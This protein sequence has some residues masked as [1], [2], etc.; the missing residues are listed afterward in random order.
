[1]QGNETEQKQPV[2][3]AFDTPD[4]GL[5]EGVVRREVDVEPEPANDR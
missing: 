4:A 5:D 2:P 1:M 3:F